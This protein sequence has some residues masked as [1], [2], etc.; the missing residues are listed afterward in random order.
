MGTRAATWLAWSLAGLSGAL[1]LASAPLVVLARS[2]HVPDSWGADL[3]V[4]SLLVQLLFLVFL[5]VGALMASGRPRNPI[6]WVC[7]ADGLL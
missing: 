6:G 1:F 3:S 2:A 4:G 5:I 7:L